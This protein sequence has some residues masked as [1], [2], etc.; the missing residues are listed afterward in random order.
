MMKILGWVGGI[1]FLI[2]GG[3]T[4]FVAI[5]SKSFLD[6]SS[7][8]LHLVCGFLLIPPGRRLLE[9]MT[10]KPWSQRRLLWTYFVVASLGFVLTF[11][12]MKSNAPRE[13]APIPLDDDLPITHLAPVK[14]DFYW[15]YIDRYGRYQIKPVYDSAT[16]FCGGLGRVK[17]QGDWWK[18]N[19][20]GQI[21][22]DSSPLPVCSENYPL[23]PVRD[24]ATGKYGYRE[25]EGKWAIP[26]QFDEAGPFHF[27][28]P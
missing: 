20:R 3:L 13:R 12:A 25:V 16:V 24:S 23:S 4:A 1:F 19:F 10:G 9:K 14:R 15:G 2:Y 5:G 26:P 27:V 7:V 22:R 6:W 28:R 18:I 17:T 8:F 21:E 11:M